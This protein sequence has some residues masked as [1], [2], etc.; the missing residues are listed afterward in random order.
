MFALRNECVPGRA[1]P[2]CARATGVSRGRNSYGTRFES[3]LTF[4]GGCWS[5]AN[6][7]ATSAEVRKGPAL[8]V[9]DDHARSFCVSTQIDFAAH[10]TRRP[11][12]SRLSRYVDDLHSIPKRRIEERAIVVDTQVDPLSAIANVARNG[13]P[14]RVWFLRSRRIGNH[15]LSRFTARQ[16]KALRTLHE[17]GSTPCVEIECPLPGA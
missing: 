6:L 3:R 12:P 13:V 7:W 2:A 9:A 17:A 10:P 1:G 4:Y 11:A 15:T 16:L 8:I 5:A 14:N